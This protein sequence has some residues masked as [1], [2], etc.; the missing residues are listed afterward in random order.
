MRQGLHCII[1]F[2]PQEQECFE[3]DIQ[4]AQARLLELARD[5][6]LKDIHIE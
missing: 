1:S 2:L 3:S 4:G 6:R 5:K